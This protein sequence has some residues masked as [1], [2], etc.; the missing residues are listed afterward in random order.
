MNV[1]SCK[2]YKEMH[3]FVDKN[4]SCRKKINP[5]TSSAVKK[6]NTERKIV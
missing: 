6:A 2:M 1:R 3:S 4:L 5:T